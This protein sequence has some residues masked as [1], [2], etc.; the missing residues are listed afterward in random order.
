[1][2][3]H[4]TIFH[5]CAAYYMHDCPWDKLIHAS[6]PCNHGLNSVIGP[7]EVVTQKMQCPPSNVRMHFSFLIIINKM[8]TLCNCT[9]STYITIAGVSP[10]T[11]RYY[12]VD[13]WAKFLI[14]METSLCNHNLL[15]LLQ[16]TCLCTFPWLFLTHWSR[17]L[18]VYLPEVIKSCCHQFKEQAIRTV[19][20]NPSRALQ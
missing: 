10:G 4:V 1:M 17:K 20:I 9:I 18:G 19:N 3:V 8:R 16:Y 13:H 14:R 5:I 7:S 6:N 12:T 2:Q 15:H 11:I